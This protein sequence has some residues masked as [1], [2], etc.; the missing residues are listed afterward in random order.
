MAHILITGGAGNI[1]S[2]LASALANDSENFIIIADNLLSGSKQ[3][4][5]KR[6]NVRFIKCDVNDYRDIAAL[7]YHYHFKY[8]FHYAAVVGV[9]RTL[10][11]PLAVLADIQGIE[12]ILKLSKNTGVERVFYSS[13]SEVYGEPVELPQHE[14]TTPL[15]SRLPYAIVKNM[16]EA[17]FKAYQQ[18]YGLNYTIFRFF[19]TYGPNQSEDFV[20]PRF[21]NLALRNKDICIY[22]DGLQSRTFLYVDDNIAA[23]INAAKSDDF[24]NQ[25]INIGSDM[26]YCIKDLAQMIVTLSNSSS[27]IKHMPP[28]AEGD[29]KR[30]CPDISNMRLLLGQ[31]IISIEEGVARLIRHYR[32][33]IHNND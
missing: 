3:K 27:K 30:R 28:L 4:V 1:G 29:M 24:I 26:E 32:P 14:Q 9:E 8:V 13:S 20:I 23:C 5:P 19:N 12:N 6:D 25:T 10:A 18:E 15:N 22:G 2:A 7:F 21:I 17:Y 33:H 11:N 31:K 16:G